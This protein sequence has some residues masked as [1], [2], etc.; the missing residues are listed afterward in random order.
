MLPRCQIAP[1]RGVQATDKRPGLQPSTTSGDSSPPDPQTPSLLL[2]EG[3]HLHSNSC[4]PGPSNQM[5]TE[6]WSFLSPASPTPPS[7]LPRPVAP[8]NL[9]TSGPLSRCQDPVPSRGAKQS[10]GS[11]FRRGTVAG[12]GFAGQEGAYLHRQG[13]AAGRRQRLWACRRSGFV[14]PT[15]PMRRGAWAAGDHEGKERNREKKL[16]LRTLLTPHGR[17]WV[18]RSPR[19]WRGPVHLPGPGRCTCQGRAGRDLSVAPLRCFLEKRRAEPGRWAADMTV[20]GLGASE[21]C[22]EKRASWRARRDPGAR[23]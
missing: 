14:V 9:G 6:G 11:R 3:P 17:P 5:V 19:V 23:M 20:R 21:S 15:T 7:P 18:K 12:R 2:C 10:A 8:N 1:A 13:R 16:T 4:R 22:G